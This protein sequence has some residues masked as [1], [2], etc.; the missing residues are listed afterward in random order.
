MSSLPPSEASLRDAMCLASARLDE[1]ET[2]AEPSEMVQA[3]TQVGRCYRGLRMLPSAEACLLQALRWSRVGS[4]ID[5]TLDLICELSETTA[6]LASHCQPLDPSRAHAAR[7]RARD[8]AFEATM[9]AGH[10]ADP[11]W[12]VQ[13]LLRISD[14]LAR[15]GDRDD[16]AQLQSRAMRL[17]AGGV[18]E[19]LD[20]ALLPSVGRLADG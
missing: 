4:A 10:V 17:M 15:C 19:P 5:G 13:V 3:L 14:V 2:R 7:E 9:L 20:P 1:A 11:G 18:V 12:E 8:H 16:A 6:A